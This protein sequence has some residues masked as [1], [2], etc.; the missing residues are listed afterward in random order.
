M[1]NK[2]IPFRPKLEGVFRTRFYETANEITDQTSP[3]ILETIISIF[4]NR[5][6]LPGEKNGR[7]EH[8]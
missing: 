1:V 6:S 8:Y 3:E 5:V 4:K 7:V 2:T